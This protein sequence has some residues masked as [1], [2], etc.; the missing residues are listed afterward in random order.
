MIYFASPT[1]ALKKFVNIFFLLLFFTGQFGYFIVYCIQQHIAHEEAEALLISKLPNSAL[2]VFS[3]Q[4]NA[5]AIHWEEKDKE[6]YL[7][8]ELYDVVRI[9]GTGNDQQIFCINDKEE[10]NIAAK[11]S[12]AA[13]SVNENSNNNKDVK[14]GIKF[15]LT[16]FLI[17]SAEKNNHSIAG[18]AE[19][20]STLN[21]RISSAIKKV[22]APPPRA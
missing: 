16:D 3:M 18:A 8:G 1:N 14:H 13:G 21:V 6:F 17:T 12:K 10:E 2:T 20:N 9:T 5:A 22:I 19:R 7:H 4:E 15:Q 11:F